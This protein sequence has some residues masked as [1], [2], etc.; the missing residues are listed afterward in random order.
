VKV[1]TAASAGRCKQPCRHGRR[2]LLLAQEQQARHVGVLATR[3]TNERPG[4]GPVLGAPQP[5][6]AL[7]R[8]ALAESCLQPPRLW[9]R[10]WAIGGDC[11]LH[12]VGTSL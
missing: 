3:E 9:R 11:R 7:A 5:C 1:L 12:E 4:L 6:S 8:R 2:R 10:L